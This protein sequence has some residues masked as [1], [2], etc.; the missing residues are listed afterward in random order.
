M[1]GYGTN[2]DLMN[3]YASTFS[4]GNAGAAPVGAGIGLL[5]GLGPAALLSFAP[6]LLGK[7]GLFGE[8]PQKKL[9]RELLKVQSPE[10]MTRLIQQYYQQASSSPA[11]AQ[12]QG[13]IAAGANQ[14]SNNVAA[15]LAQR[16]IGTSGVG[17]VL[18]GL[19]PSLVGSQMAGLRTSLY[20]GAQNQAQSTIEQQI[21]A[22]LGTS[23][24]S[25]N[26]QLAGAGI[27]S[28]APFLQS[29]LQSRFPNFA[30]MGAVA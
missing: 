1:A 29:Y 21:K 17:A 14:A 11:F 13:T 6:A 30:K 12:A 2:S 28:L 16:G 7:L 23:G 24:P 10:N 18:S 26:Q 5:G 15:N 4:G 20:Q 3:Q 27:N 19:T 8:D 25:Q 9:R 22:L